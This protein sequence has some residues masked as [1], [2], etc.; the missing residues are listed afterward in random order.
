MKIFD[1]N[2]FQNDFKSLYI[3]AGGFEDRVRGILSRIELVNMEKVF[4]YSIILKY[5][6]HIDDNKNNLLYLEDKMKLISKN[7][8]PNVEI[9]ISNILNSNKHLIENFQPL[10]NFNIDQIFV[11]ISGMSNFLILLIL[12]AL[13]KFF[14]NRNIKILYTEAKLYFPNEEE[15]KQI[16]DLIENKTDDNILKL[17]ELLQVSGARDSLILSEYKGLFR[18]D[19]PIILI[20]FVGHEPSRAIGLLDNYRPDIIIPLYGESPH[21]N[22]KWRTEFSIKLHNNFKVFDSFKKP[23]ENILISTFEIK[24]IIN[25]LEE[26]YRSEINKKIIYE[27]FNVAIS[28]QCSKLQTIATFIFCQTHPDIQVVFCLPDK[29]NPKRY[30]TGIGNSWIYNLS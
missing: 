13:L 12:K 20:F 24:E 18:E 22:L 15:Q 4:D 16:F 29:Y 14:P 17:S 6:T 30:S 5:V 2:I 10:I 23:S 9:D 11:D 27:N 28:P 26:I 19:F 25:K 1:Q 8:L 3:C 21:K 7:I